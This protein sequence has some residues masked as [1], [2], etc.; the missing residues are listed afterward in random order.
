MFSIPQLT[1]ITVVAIAATIAVWG[2][3]RFIEFITDLVTTLFSLLLY[4][5]SIISAIA[6]SIGS[7]LLII[8]LLSDPL[9]VNQLWFYLHQLWTSGLE[10]F[11]DN[12][13]FIGLRQLQ[14]SLRTFWSDS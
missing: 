13:G 7:V 11:R 5:I 10:G 12:G 14:E 8:W 3:R 9:H 6:L 2:I 1:V 4:W